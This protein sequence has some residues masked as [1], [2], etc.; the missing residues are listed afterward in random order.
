MR[1]SHRRSQLRPSNDVSHDRARKR[2]EP[3]ESRRTR[4]EAVS[5]VEIPEEDDRTL[6]DLMVDHIEF[7]NKVDIALLEQVNHVQSV[8][9]TLNSSAELL[10]SV[11]CAVLLSKVVGTGFFDMEKAEE[12]EKWQKDVAEIESGVTSTPGTE[13]YGFSSVFFK[14]LPP[15]HPAR[16]YKFVSEHFL[17]TEEYG[18]EEYEGGT[19]PLLNASSN[20]KGDE[21]SA[22]N[23]IEGA[24]SDDAGGSKSAAASANGEDCHNGNANNEGN[25]D[26]TKMD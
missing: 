1:H 10:A 17:L 21:S 26:V 19:N 7:A 25:A 22:T 16:L 20:G 13:E 6:A 9:K 4:G 8:V 24:K 14:V 18:E 11:N 15:F 23:G 12:M 5:R 3:E 2:V